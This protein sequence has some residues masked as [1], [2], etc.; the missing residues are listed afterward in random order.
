VCAALVIQHASACAVLY[1]HM[2]PVWLYHIFQQY[3]MNGLIFGQTLLN[4][5]HVFCFSYNLFFWNISH[6]KKNSVSY[7][8][9]TY[10]LCK[11]SLFLSDFDEPRIILTDFRKIILYYISWKSV[12]WD[13]SFFMRTDRHIGGRT[14][15]RT[16]RQTDEKKLIV[17]F[18]NFAN[19]PDVT[20]ERQYN[21]LIV[22][23]RSEEE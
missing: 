22:G 5:K 21:I 3:L 19:T 16:D 13:S 11:Y 9:C 18:H 6:S 17:A 8:K 12:Q 1:W 2:W 7:R 14:D 4:I 23:R 20:Y 10:V 15:G